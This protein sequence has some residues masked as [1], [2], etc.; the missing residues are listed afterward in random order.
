MCAGQFSGY[1]AARQLSGGLPH[2]SAERPGR[3]KQIPVGDHPGSGGGLPL[4]LAVM[5]CPQVPIRP[6]RGKTPRNRRDNIPHGRIANLNLLLAQ[7]GVEGVHVPPAAVLAGRNGE[8]PIL[9]SRCL[10]LRGPFAS[11]LTNQ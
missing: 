8:E 10:C 4:G 3:K 6:G 7:I 9:P 5:H 11:A 2:W 1:P